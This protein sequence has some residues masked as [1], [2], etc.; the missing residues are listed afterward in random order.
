MLLAQ[1]AQFGP[2]AMGREHA[3]APP[4]IR[5]WHTRVRGMFGSGALPG[6]P[7]ESWHATDRF[8]SVTERF[9]VAN[10]AGRPDGRAPAARTGATGS[11]AGGV[12]TRDP[13]GHESFR[14]RFAALW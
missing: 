10:S 5:P 11:P 12:C 13:Y 9:P 4:G 6:A 7:K 1:S 8:R 14:T 3:K 2:E